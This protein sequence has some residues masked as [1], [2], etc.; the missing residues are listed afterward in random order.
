M[1]E[2]AFEGPSRFSRVPPFVMDAS[3]NSL[4]AWGMA[5]SAL[6][7]GPDFLI[8]GAKRAGT[9]TLYHALRQHPEVGALFP[10]QQR[11]K[12]PH[13]FALEHDRGVRWYRSHFPMRRPFGLTRPIAGDADP[14]LLYHPLAPER[15]AL[16]APGARVLILLRDPVERAWSHHWDRVKNGVET[17]EFEDAIAAEPER[18]SGQE[19]LLLADPHH[20]SHAHEHYSYLDRGRYAVQVRRWLQHVPADKILIARC[21]DLYRDPQA[22]FDVVCD[23]LGLTPFTPSRF[24]KHHAHADRPRVPQPIR[25]RV[26][27]AFEEQNEDLTKVLDTPLWWDRTGATTLPDLGVVRPSAPF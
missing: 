15:V 18:L 21:E 8:V 6:R 25:N 10:P 19:E 24:G 23:F 11:I 20:V 27:P 22:V 3:K 4:R 26:F 9:T 1:T 16:E 14:Y 13:Y 5:T 7:P 17:L 12:S 2:N